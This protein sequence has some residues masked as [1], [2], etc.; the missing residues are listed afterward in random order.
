M[1][2]LDGPVR[3]NVGLLG[4]PCFEIPRSVQ[5]DSRFDRLKTG[6]E[7]RRRLAAKNKHNLATMA[8]F[9]LVRW[10]HLAVITVLALVA[11]DLYHLAGPFVIVKFALLALAFSVAY[12][13]LVERAVA[14]FQAL[15]PQFCSVYEPY[16][17]WHERYWKH[18]MPDLINL[19]NGTP[20]KGPIWRL[21]GVRVGP[22]LFDDGCGI[23]EKT[24]V[25]I[26][27]DCTLNAGTVIQCHS[28]E[29]GTFK[30]DHVAIG[31]GCTLGVKAFVHYGVKLGDGAVLDA[32][33]FLMK[34]E[35]VAS[36]A[37]WRGNPA[38]EVW[39]ARL[40]DRAAATAPVVAAAAFPCLPEG[41]D[42]GASPS[43]RYG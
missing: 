6:E 3:E 23:P 13:A 40:P 18:L 15:R 8:L 37:R 9:L 38:R 5:R 21:L 30:S 33:S 17:W 35:E 19:F 1:V 29:D 16:Y 27:A 2:P 11:L 34:G 20:L 43:R 41:A 31:A 4:S 12:F 24:L 14:G 42:D 25:A 26:G 36:H 10:A 22:R 32:D 7:F 39:D 28:L